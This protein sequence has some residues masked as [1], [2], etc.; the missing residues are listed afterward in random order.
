MLAAHY[1]KPYVGMALGIEIP[2]LWK[3]EIGYKFGVDWAVKWYEEKFGEPAP[4][5][6]ATPPKERVLWTYTGTFSDPVK[7]YEAAKTQIAQGAVAVYNVGGPIGLGIFQAAREA[8]EAEGKTTGP[9]FGIG[10]DA[11]QDWVEP[12]WII[13]SM[14]KRVDTGVYE[15]A[16]RVVEGTFEGGILTLGPREEGIAM[17]TLEDMDTFLRL[18]VEA[19]TVDPADRDEIF[20]T[21][22][23]MR[24]AQPDWIWEGAAELETQILGEIV[25]LA[26]TAE[27]IAFWREVYG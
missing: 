21:V 11:D 22:K 18:G 24:D 7:G 13:V 3:F 25:P 14:M 1:E 2:V 5:I 16:K 27:E 6:G 20:D 10:V 19:G 23:A 15:A 8:G 26:F 9:P 12:G 4:G 17:S